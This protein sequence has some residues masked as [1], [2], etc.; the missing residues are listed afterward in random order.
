M[1]NWLI[2]KIIGRVIKTIVRISPT[3]SRVTVSAYAD[4]TYKTHVLYE[5]LTCVQSVPAAVWRRTGRTT[6]LWCR[7]RTGKLFSLPDQMHSV[8]SGQEPE[9]SKDI[10]TQSAE[11]NHAEKHKQIKRFGWN[12]LIVLRPVQYDTVTGSTSVN[13]WWHHIIDLTI[14]PSL[15]PTMVL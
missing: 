15:F 6:S 13:R 3:H 11:K 7:R 8:T 1:M 12:R 5:Y 9:M 10:L 2:W 4:P 14:L